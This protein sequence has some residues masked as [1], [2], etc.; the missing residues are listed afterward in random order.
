[1]NLLLG[2]AEGNRLVKFSGVWFDC[3]ISSSEIEM[4]ILLAMVDV[5]DE[6]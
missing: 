2:E 1:M 4:S 6:I 3:P 5:P